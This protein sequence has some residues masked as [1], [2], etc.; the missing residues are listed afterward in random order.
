MLYWK[1]VFGCALFHVPLVPPTP[2]SRCL[3]VPATVDGALKSGLASQP[4]FSLWALGKFSR[5]SK[6][7][8]YPKIHESTGILHFI[9]LDST[10]NYNG[11]FSLT[12][13]FRFLVRR[14][15]R[16]TGGQIHEKCLQMV[17]YLRSNYVE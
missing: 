13:L 9:W 4:I 7:P 3:C 17:K 10:Y 16:E 15:G 2:L 6:L 11:T 8:G 12:S 14:E 1:M 5:Q